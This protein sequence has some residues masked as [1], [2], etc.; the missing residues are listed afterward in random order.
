[1]ALHGL[2][3]WRIM[4][5]ISPCA[6]PWHRALQ[7]Y[8]ER[9]RGLR[10]GSVR[11]WRAGGLLSNWARHGVLVVHVVISE[12]RPSEEYSHEANWSEGCASVRSHDNL[13]MV[14]FLTLAVGVG[15]TTLQIRLLLI[16]YEK[17][18]S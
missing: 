16:A 9:S 12:R 6:W 1:M 10:I 13:L 18:L 4:A 5:A 8:S 7:A 11:R 15:K 14:V 17:K 3:F 2:P